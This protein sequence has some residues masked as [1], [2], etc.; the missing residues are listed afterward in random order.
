MAIKI[1]LTIIFKYNNIIIYAR[2]EMTES[3][4]SKPHQPPLLKGRI[5]KGEG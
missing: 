3:I 5:L 1:S 4:K 2:V